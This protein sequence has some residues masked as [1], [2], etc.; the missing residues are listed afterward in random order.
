MQPEFRK[1]TE[2]TLTPLTCPPE[3]ANASEW[4]LLAKAG[5][6]GMVSLMMLLVWWKRAMTNRTVYEED[7][8]TQWALTVKDVTNV[9][10][11]LKAMGSQAFKNLPK[12]KPADTNENEPD[13]GSKRFVFTTSFALYSHDLIFV[14]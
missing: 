10:F 6:N 9:L 12:R 13:S 8:S 5:Q 7:S 2:E 3:P 14:V 1:T 11:L 4:T